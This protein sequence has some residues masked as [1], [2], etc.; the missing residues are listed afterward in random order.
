[1]EVSSHALELERVA[2]VRFA[3]A[4]FTNLTQDHLDFHPDMEALLRRQ[5]AAVPRAP[6]RAINVDDAY[7]RRLA[8]EA[9]GP[10]L[11]YA[12]R[13]DADADVRPHAVEIGAGGVDRR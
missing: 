10:V 11:T 3:A 13:A 1:M 5:G 2:G 6:R 7:G 9:G 4:A 12:A 8:G